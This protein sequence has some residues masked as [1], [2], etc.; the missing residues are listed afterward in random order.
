[1]GT[2]RLCRVNDNPRMTYLRHACKI[3]DLLCPAMGPVMAEP[4]RGGGVGDKGWM[5]LEWVH[6]H[7]GK[8]SACVLQRKLFELKRQLRQRVLI[9]GA[10]FCRTVAIRE[11]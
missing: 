4:A 8:M 9:V 5:Q 1:M 2:R 6:L 11:G 7:A 10:N 3:G